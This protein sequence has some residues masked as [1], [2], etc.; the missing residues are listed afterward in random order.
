MCINM[1]TYIYIYTICIYAYVYTCTY[2]HTCICICISVCLHTLM[3]VV[4]VWV[5]TCHDIMCGGHLVSFGS[6]LLQCGS[7]G[8]ELRQSG[9]MLDSFTY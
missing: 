4:C 3:Y 8:I 2:I 6:L 1:Y 7:W 9:L 5:H